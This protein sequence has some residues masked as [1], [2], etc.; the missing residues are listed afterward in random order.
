MEYIAFSE[1]GNRWENQDSYRIK[2]QDDGLL[3]ICCDGMAHHHGLESSETVCNAIVGFWE[4]N[5]DFVDC[6]DKIRKAC[7]KASEALNKHADELSHAEMGTTM[8]MASIEGDKA[9]IAYSGDSRC[10]LLRPSEG[11]IYQTKDHIELSFGWEVLT[12][13][14]FSYRSEKLVHA[15]CQQSLCGIAGQIGDIGTEPCV[16]TGAALS[17]DEF[18]ILH[19]QT[20][21]AERQCSFRQT[22]AWQSGRQPAF[23]RGRGDPSW[24]VQRW[25]AFS[26]IPQRDFLR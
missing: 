16:N 26:Q 22:A 12:N 20:L 6:E 25:W 24:A 3:L 15:L 21:S 7:K 2:Q 23:L 10:Y 14:F 9:T 19:R 1:C 11:L 8:V 13:S 4:Q 17:G 18:N 5:Q